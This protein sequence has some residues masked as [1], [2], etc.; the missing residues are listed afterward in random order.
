[1]VVLPDCFECCE[2][3]LDGVEVWRIRRQE[4]QDR[5]FVFDQLFCFV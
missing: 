4:E 1:M 2:V 3:L 5:A